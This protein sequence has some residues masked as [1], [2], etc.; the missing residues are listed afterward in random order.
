MLEAWCNFILTALGR[1]SDYFYVGSAILSAVLL[2]VLVLVQVRY[3]GVKSNH[4]S[5]S[6]T[7]RKTT[8]PRVTSTTQMGTVGTVYTQASSK[9]SDV[10]S[11]V[12]P[13]ADQTKLTVNEGSESPAS[14]S[15]S[16]SS[17]S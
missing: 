9:Q 15:S 4:T 16:S 10:D 6:S 1:A 7:N 11:K 17:S 12:E 8:M 14:D 13:E 3:L 5:S 2:G